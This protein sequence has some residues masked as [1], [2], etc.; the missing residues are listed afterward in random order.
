VLERRKAIYNQGYGQT[1][2]STQSNVV[3]TLFS[4][5]EFNYQLSLIGK[6]KSSSTKTEQIYIK[7]KIEYLSTNVRT[8]YEYVIYCF[9]HQ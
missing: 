8:N 1:C 6:T 2:R 7:K 4:S 9:K 3:K 5:K